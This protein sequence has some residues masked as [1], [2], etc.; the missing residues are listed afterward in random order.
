MAIATTLASPCE[1]SQAGAPAAV[2][3]VV[4][5]VGEHVLAVHA[6]AE[7]RNRDAQLCCRD[8]PILPRR[9]A[10]HGLHGL[11]QPVAAGRTG[12]D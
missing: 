12:V 6:E 7:A 8:V 2:D 4:D 1:T 5:P 3:A 9:I 11:G 10:Q